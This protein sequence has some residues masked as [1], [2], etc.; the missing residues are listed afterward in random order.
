MSAVDRMLEKMSIADV[1]V[2]IKISTEEIESGTDVVYW[3]Y[4]AMKA[5][6]NLGNRLIQLKKNAKKEVGK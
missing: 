2:V 3:K 4:V 5:N 1:G 6:H